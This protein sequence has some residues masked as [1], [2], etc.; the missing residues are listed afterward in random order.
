MSETLTA[1]ENIAVSVF[2]NILSNDNYTVEVCDAGDLAFGVSQEGTNKGP[3]PGVTGYAAETGESLK[4]YTIGDTCVIT[5][6][7]TITAGAYLK[8][9]ADGE[10]T[11]ATTGQAYSAIALNDAA[12][13]ERVKAKL[14]HGVTP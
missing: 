10:A 8:P 7:A 1:S 4:V 5:A 3:I 14:E 13:G 12:A 9:S 6:D 2:V 11:P